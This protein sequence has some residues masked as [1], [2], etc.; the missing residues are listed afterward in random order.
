VLFR[1]VKALRAYIQAVRVAGYYS[2]HII[3]GGR[4]IDEWCAWAIDHANRLDP[5]VTS[6]QRSLTK[7]IGSIGIDDFPDISCS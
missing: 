7:R 2:L 5:T 3:T 1:W 6:S 4:N